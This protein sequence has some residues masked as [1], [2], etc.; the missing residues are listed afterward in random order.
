ML[1]L[2]KLWLC[3]LQRSLNTLTIFVQESEYTYDDFDY[4]IELRSTPDEEI[5]FDPLTSQPEGV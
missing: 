4:I 5:K 3:Q 1:C 2:K